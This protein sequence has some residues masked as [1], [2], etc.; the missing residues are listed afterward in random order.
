V[1]GVSDKINI[2]PRPHLAI[3][4]RD[5]SEICDITVCTASEQDYADIIIDK[6]DPT[7]K[8]TQRFYRNVKRKCLNHLRIAQ[9]RLEMNLRKIFP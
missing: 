9:G 7:G 8:I 1:A 4:L 6:I 5:A 2:A 3:F